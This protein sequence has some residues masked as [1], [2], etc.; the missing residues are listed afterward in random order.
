LFLNYNY[1]KKSCFSFQFNFSSRT[2]SSAGKKAWINQMLE[3]NPIPSFWLSNS[4][5]V[6]DKAILR[7]F[8]YVLRLD[9]PKQRVRSEIIQGY[10]KQFAVSEAWVEQIAA[11][12]HLAP[13]IVERA[14]Q[15]EVKQLYFGCQE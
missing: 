14:I 7:R 10:F 5:R 3:S 4:V 2:R 8:D 11:C 1:D 12:D 6:I 13:A 9:Y 15:T